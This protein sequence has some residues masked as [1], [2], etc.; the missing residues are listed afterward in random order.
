MFDP[1][2]VG[3]WAVPLPPGTSVING[4]LVAIR[5]EPR[6][7]GYKPGSGI[8]QSEPVVPRFKGDGTAE[9]TLPHYY[10][11]P[12]TVIVNGTPLPASA[13]TRKPGSTAD[14]F[15]RPGFPVTSNDDVAFAY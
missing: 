14:F 15:I 4:H 8:R 13:I 12:V 5:D 1:N 3:K 9:V 6:P 10:G 11:T 2:N 7:E